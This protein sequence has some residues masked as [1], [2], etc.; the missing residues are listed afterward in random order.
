[1]LVQERAVGVEF[2]PDRLERVPA[3]VPLRERSGVGGVEFPPVR[4]AAELPEDGLAAV[5]VLSIGLP[6]VGVDR[7]ERGVTGVGG[8][9][10]GLVATD[11]AH[12]DGELDVT[13]TVGTTDDGFYLED[14]G[15]GFAVDPPERVLDAGFTTVEENTGFGLY[16]ASSIAQDHGW[17]LALS[18]SADGGA[19]FDISGVALT[20]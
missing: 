1:M 8:A 13:V 19:R 5:E 6:V 20:D 4:A 17:T 7:D 14:D 18:E 15:P 11:E 16:V 3:R 9:Q 10:Q 2:S 12:L